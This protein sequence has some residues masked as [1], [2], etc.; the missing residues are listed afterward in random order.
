[1]Q[2]TDPFDP[3]GGMA[4]IVVESRQLYLYGLMAYYA[5]DAVTAA[6]ADLMGWPDTDELADARRRL[7]AITRSFADQLRDAE[8]DDPR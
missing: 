6:R 1:M 8:F 4:P 2:R 3:N 5:C 7:R